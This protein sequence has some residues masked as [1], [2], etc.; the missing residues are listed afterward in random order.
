MSQTNEHVFESNVIAMLA[1]AGWRSGDVADWDKG[2]AL[3]PSHVVGFIQATQPKLWAHMLDLHGQNLPAMLVAALV[4]ELDAKGSLHVLRHGFKFFGKTF[5]LAYFKPAHGLSPD[6]QALYAS[7]DIT[8]TRQVPCHPERGDTADMVFAVNGLPVATCELKNPSTGQTWRNAIAQYREDRDPRTPLFGFKS[9]ALVHFAADPDEVHMCTRLAG[10]G[11]VFL[12]FNRGSHPGQA[13]CGK[14]NPGHLSGYRTGYL[15]S[16]VLGRDSFLDILGHYMFLDRKTEKV[17]DEQGERHVTKEKLIFP[18][19]HQLDAV[20]RLIAASREQGPG[21]NYLIQHS[22]GSG[23]TNSISWLS[24][25]LASLHDAQ[26]RKLF[27]CVIVITDR[28]VLDRQLQDAIYQIEHAQGV[29]KAIDQDAKQLAAALVDGTKIVITTLQKFPFVLRGLLRVAGAAGLEQATEDERKQAKEWE[30]AIARRR[31]AVIVDEAHSSQ[32]GETAR[33]LK[34]IL[35]SGSAA[36]GGGDDDET[37]ADWEDGLNQVLLSRGRQPNLAF[38]AFTATPKGKTLELFGQPGPDGKPVPFHIYSMRQAIE[39]GFILDVLSNYTT[40]A[41]YFRLIKAVAD[42][43]ALPKKKAVKELVKFL[44]LHPYN[45]E[46]K[47]EVMVEHF[48][49]SVRHRLGGKAKAM[50]VTSSRLHAVRYMQAFG[51]YIE[52]KGYTDVRP[53]V[54]F[55]GT[56]KDPDTGQEFTEPGMN[57]DCVTGR[58]I[59]EAQLPERFDSPDYNVLLVANKYQTGFDQPLLHTMY[60]DKRLDGVQAVQTLSRLNRMVPGKSAPFVLDFVN[61][62]EDIFR[63]FKPY[64]DATTLQEKSDSALLEQ[65]KH[66]L[67]LVQVYH[68]SEVEA[69]ARVFYK[70]VASQAPADHAALERHLQPAVDR[71]KGL[72]DEEQRT[73]FRDKLS[74]YVNLYAFLSQVIPYG[75]QDL[76]MLYTFGRFLLPHLPHGVDAARVRLGDEVSLRYYR[77]ERLSSGAID[78]AAG[79][80]PGVKSPTATGTGKAQEQQAPLSE[81]IQTLNDRLGTQFTEEDRLF[82]QQIKERACSNEQVVQT[83]LAN[84]LDKFSLGIKKLIADLMLERMAE[85]DKIVTRYMADPTFQGAAF[86]ILA[87]EI[88]DAVRSEATNPAPGPS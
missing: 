36:L 48:R 32:T 33:E 51:R 5:R 72:P 82:F 81:I 69:F 20:T 39:E 78:L 34:S 4:K 65:L 47:T 15:W 80:D 23:K 12:P 9:R 7:N 58:P 74:G 60:V 43:P 63:A 19:Y 59:S 55:S 10:E 26:D 16:E 11:S 18:R 42:D 17:A 30:E 67:D 87:R 8:V 40:Y 64:Y 84:P 6:V 27:D 88:F 49:R 24:H 35:G 52:E 79:D 25:R 14:G 50:V 21:S 22:A 28:K 73:A 61:Q 71:F 13:R 31:Y 1:K 2:L 85:N 46:Q 76:E 68:S 44:T 77:M 66:E 3:F 29:V 70:P 53:L 54:A 57:I 83:A 38:Y 56:V 41:T 86:P 75:D 62:A 37:P 45:L